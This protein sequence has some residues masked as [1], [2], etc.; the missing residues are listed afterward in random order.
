MMETLLVFGVGEVLLGL[1]SDRVQRVQRVPVLTDVPLAQGALRGIAVMEGRIVPVLD[2]GALLG[3]PPVEADRADARLVAVQVGEETV[4]FLV[5][6]IEQTLE[7][8]DA[9]LEPVDDQL[10]GVIGVVA[11]GGRPVQV[12]APEALLSDRFMEGHQPWHAPLPLP[13]AGGIERQD[14]AS[15]GA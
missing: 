3:L 4:G 11:H 2:M 14:D 9:D 12:L 8:S 13:Q 10:K 6:R 5:D 7:V 15:D 1:D